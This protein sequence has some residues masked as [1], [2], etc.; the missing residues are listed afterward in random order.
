MSIFV[1]PSLLNSAPRFLILPMVAYVMWFTSFLPK[2]A[3]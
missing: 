1:K 3:E 2:L